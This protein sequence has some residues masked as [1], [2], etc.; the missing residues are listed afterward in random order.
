MQLNTKLKSFFMSYIAYKRNFVFTA[1]AF[2]TKPSGL[3][4]FTFTGNVD[5]SFKFNSAGEAQDAIDSFEDTN[6]SNT[7]YIIEEREIN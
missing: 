1:P 7:Y 4:G 2:V 5:K 6:T 3:N